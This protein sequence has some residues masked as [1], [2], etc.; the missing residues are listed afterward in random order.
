M[1]ESEIKLEDFFTR[2]MS[3][4]GR[5]TETEVAYMLKKTAKT[6]STAESI[7][8]GLIASKLTSQPGSSEFF[9]GGIIS[10]HNKVKVM[11]LGVS[12]AIIA[13][14]SPVSGDVAKAMAEGIRK[15]YR[16]DIGIASTGVAGPGTV[17]PPK[18]IGLT[19]IALATDQGTIVN[20]LNLTGTR[21]EVRE[22]AA[23]AALGM[24]WLSLG[25]EEL[26]KTL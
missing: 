17:S 24:L 22:K 21:G 25:G 26:L 14:Q 10:Y 16:T 2:V 19:Y 5:T 7:T 8:G 9:I 6:I 12:A 13:N 15:R 23:A 3:I 20:E 4:I 18:P 1:A 11:D